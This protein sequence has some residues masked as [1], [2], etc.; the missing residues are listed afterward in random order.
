[1]QHTAT[2]PSVFAPQSGASDRGQ[3]TRSQVR[4]A[5]VVLVYVCLRVERV[6]GFRPG[7]GWVCVNIQ[8]HG[9]SVSV[10]VCVCAW[11]GGSGELRGLLGVREPHHLKYSFFFCWEGG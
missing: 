10:C 7:V 11:T 8:D 3:A 9:V 2:T 5:S 4:S 1:M 6:V